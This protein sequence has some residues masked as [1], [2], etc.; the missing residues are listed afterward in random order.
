MRRTAVLIVWL[1]ADYALFLGSYVLAY[2]NR[3]GWILSSDLPFDRFMA[4]VAVSGV[5]WLLVLVGTRTFGL[6][7]RQRTLRNAAYIGYASVMGTVLV[8]F[9]YFFLYQRV[10]SRELLLTACILSALIT[11]TWHMVAG[12][13]MR[14]VLRTNP[15]AYPTLIIGVTRETRQL[16]ALLQERKSPIMP[17]A[18]LDA[19]G[20]KDKE[21]EG[22][23]IVGKLDKLDQTLTRYGI[24]HVIQCSDLEQSI[25][26]LSACRAAGITYML[27]PSVLGIIERDERVETLEGKS[28]TVVAPPRS[29]VGWF[30]R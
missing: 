1:L 8:A 21:I 29:G 5:P 9:V 17:V 24:T 14:T 30:F 10:F 2:F 11:W 16:L 20:V 4:A 13:L 26:L 6:T 3:V 19:S 27:L 18:I 25:N 28:V 15:P 12:L 22:V 7:R 23:P